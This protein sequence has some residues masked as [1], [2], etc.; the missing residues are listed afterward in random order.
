MGRK[1]KCE[2]EIN[3]D[4]LIIKPVSGAHH[5]TNAKFAEEVM[6]FTWCE[7][8]NGYLQTWNT[9]KS[10][11]EIAINFKSIFFHRFVWFLEHGKLPFYQIDHIDR[12]R[13]NSM[14]KNLRE[15]T[16]QENNKNRSGH[17]KTSS[18]YKGIYWDTRLGKWGARIKPNGTSIYLGSF[19]DEINAAIAYDNAARIHGH[20]PNF[21]LH[22]GENSLFGMMPIQESNQLVLF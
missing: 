17:R 2:F 10:G 16:S 22:P 3:S 6:K 13:V 12:N 7:V 5:F 21:S 11:L 19:R 4:R 1:S 18:K 20:T 14:I 15:C 8:K 9:R